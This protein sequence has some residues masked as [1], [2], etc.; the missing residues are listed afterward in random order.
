M[1]ALMTAFMFIVLILNKGEA[2]FVSKTSGVQNPSWLCVSKD[3][4]FVYAVNENGGDKPGEVS[5]FAFD[6]KSGQ[7]TLLNKQ[8]TDGFAPCSYY[9]RCI[10]QKCDHCK[11]CRWEYHCV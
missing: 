3:G 6:K 9:Y 7:L 2:T 4:K 10:R 8:P 1:E 11:L 5:S